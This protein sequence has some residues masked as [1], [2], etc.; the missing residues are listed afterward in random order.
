MT[1]GRPRSTTDVRSTAAIALVCTA[2]LAAL[3]GE[4]R[5]PAGEA[6]TAAYLESIRRDPVALRAFLFELPKGADLHLHLSGAVYAES[7]LAWAA[8]AALC[9]DLT[10]E[11]YVEALVSSE[12]VRCANAGERPASDVLTHPDLYGRLVD[13]LS[14]RHHDPSRG[15]DESRFFSTF[16]RFLPIWRGGGVGSERVTARALAEV[17]SR[18]ERQHVRHLEIILGLDDGTPARLATEVPWP[19]AEDFSRYRQAL[20]DGGLRDLVPRRRRWLD[21]VERETEEVLACRTTPAPPGCGISRRYIATV[22]RALSPAQVF[23]QMLFAFELA[24]SDA[25]VVAV[26]P[27][28]P[29]DWFVPR[30]D[31]D[32]HLR[33]FAFMHAR[34]PGVRISLHAGELTLGQVPPSELGQHVRKAVEAGF[35]SRI[36]HG[37]DVLYDPHADELLRDMASRRIGVEINFTTNEQILGV[38]GPRHPFRHYMRAGVPVTIS[39]D[40]EGVARTDIT[41][42]YQRAVE[43]HGASYAELKR[44]SRNGLEQSFLP[45][46]ERTRLTTALEAAFVAFESRTWGAATPTRPPGP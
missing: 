39:T 12:G 16:D 3:S 15:P 5:P 14:M 46:E 1:V 33:M 24:S 34:Y 26:N 37:V 31:Y 8:D 43:E 13:A 38:S 32:L 7:Y 20:L 22:L 41:H 45:A 18:A 17:S 11:T 23:A 29:E 44:I 28:Q 35:A 2:W 36:G 9:V 6:R 27:V 4:T 21:D 40:D 19:S 10:R 42:E 25:R 30:R